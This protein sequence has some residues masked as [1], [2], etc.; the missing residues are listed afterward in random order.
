MLRFL[1]RTVNSSIMIVKK[2][3]KFITS[4]PVKKS[5]DQTNSKVNNT[6]VPKLQHDTILLPLRRQCHHLLRR[7][8]TQVPMPLRGRA[9]AHRRRSILAQLHHVHRHLKGC[10][11]ET[12]NLGICRGKRQLHVQPLLWRMWKPVVQDFNRIPG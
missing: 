2:S 8:R 10:Q 6:A 9:Q 1:Y 5:N 11:G 7:A 12:Q 4:L 3:N